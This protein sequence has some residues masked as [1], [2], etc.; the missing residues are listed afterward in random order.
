MSD[1]Y[2]S[3][4][5]SAATSQVDKGECPDCQRMMS[6]DSESSSPLPGSGLVV[7]LP[8]L[9]EKS[10]R[11]VACQSELCDSGGAHAAERGAG[12]IIVSELLCYLQNR[13]DEL[14]H[15]II[16]KA[17]I[18]FYSETDIE[19]A[20]KLLF[21][22]CAAF[23]SNRN[24]KRKG[25]NKKLND[26]KD[27]IN[28]MNEVGIHQPTFV[29][30]KLS[31]VPPVDLSNFEITKVC[32]ELAEMRVHVQGLMGVQ[33]EVQALSSLLREMVANPNTGHVETNDDGMSLSRVNSK[34]LGG[35][36]CIGASQNSINAVSDNHDAISHDQENSSEA[37]V[38]QDEGSLHP[39]TEDMGQRGNDGFIEVKRQPQRLTRTFYSTV[40]KDHPAETRPKLA[41][42]APLK[43]APMRRQGAKPTLLA[44]KNRRM[45]SKA[46]LFVTRL[47][48]GTS[49]ADVHQH[50]CGIVKKNG[51][52]VVCEKL[53]TRYEGY[54]SFH[55][56]V[57][58]KAK[59]L[60]SDSKQWPEG[61]LVRRYFA[62]RNN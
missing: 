11:S 48:Q 57:P 17:V 47:C 4:K 44:S 60:V 40:L 50:V 54:S 45:E 35:V 61:V 24:V 27:I 31:A 10:S 23:T 38:I 14:P 46:E 28:L 59:D 30:K 8:P 42:A 58:M 6:P 16:C 15:D 26:A 18:E 13:V 33:S 21:D 22:S 25:S 43:A 37:L 7:K 39:S 29:A 19:T 62:K 9:D 52:A 1:L 12:V 2:C 55:I 41:K 32:H 49:V 5:L 51:S 3:C 34:D 56:T 20:K 36:S 53:S